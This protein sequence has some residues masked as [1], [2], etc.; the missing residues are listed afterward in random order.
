MPHKKVIS[1][2]I[3]KTMLSDDEP[4]T[5]YPD[6]KLSNIS[7]ENSQ[8]MPDNLLWLLSDSSLVSKTIPTSTQ[9]WKYSQ[10]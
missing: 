2:S 3:I 5:R 8:C 4:Y 1:D 9:E 7:D 6:K 10:H